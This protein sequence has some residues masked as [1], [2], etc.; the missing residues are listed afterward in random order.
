MVVETHRPE[1]RNRVQSL[2][3]FLVF[4]SMAVAS[5]SSGQILASNGW[6]AVNWVVFPPV[7]FAITALAMIGAYR[8]REALAN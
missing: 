6:E 8:R 2:N 1:E 3:D 7:V 5:F 4:G